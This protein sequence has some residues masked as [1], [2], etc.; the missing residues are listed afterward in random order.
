MYTK[1]VQLIN[2][3]P[4]EKLDIELPFDGETPKPVILVGENGSGKSILLSHLVDGLLKAKDTVYPQTP[5]IETGRVYKF[6]TNFYIKSGSQFSFG[7]VDFEEDF[8]VSE[9][10]TMRPKQEYSEVPSGMLGTAAEPIWRRMDPV[11]SDH[12]D[13]NLSI[14]YAAF[15][16]LK[17]I[18]ARNCVLYFPF[19]RFEEPAW[20]NHENLTAE[21]QYV[22]GKRLVDHTGRRAIALSPLH[23]NQ[24]WI[25][26][27]IYDRRVPETRT[28]R[29]SMPTPVGTNPWYLEAQQAEMRSH[30]E[31]VLSTA[32]QVV[33]N[34][35]RDY[36]NASFRIGRRRNRF[37]ALHGDNGT[38]VP[39]I[40]QLSSG[41][42]SLLN[43]FLSIL[44][45]YEWTD[46]QFSSATEIRGIVVVDEVDLHLHAIHQHE[47]LPK[48]IAM[49]PNV[50]FI[51]TTHSP[52]FVLG[53]QQTFGEDGFGIYR[54]SE[55]DRISAEEFS[56]FSE[57]YKTFSATRRFFN[58]LHIAIEEAQKPVLLTEG[59]TDEKYIRRASELLGR[60]EAL[61]GFEIRDGG[62]SG[63][64]ANVWKNYKYPMT[65]LVS[66]KVVLLFDCDKN[67][68][69]ENRENLF[70]RTIPFQPDN[71][72]ET[73]IENLFS[74]STLD[75]ATQYKAEFI[76]I[77]LEHKGTK[78]GVEI[79][80]LEK[81]TV[82][83]D[84]K[85]NLCNWIC[86]N[87]T[88]EDF[89]QFGVIFD[90]M[91]EVLGLNP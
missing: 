67:R 64:L 3:G 35:L 32:L 49:F 12:P 29:V 79:V 11:A 19:N 85:M 61:N 43:L 65:E 16:R 75:K 41:E 56:E 91:E 28:V 84:E 51:L 70:Q 50:Q 23:E 71:P 62:G 66:Q 26:D 25:F 88:A 63:N 87:G 6:R 24:N 69:S 90:L 72:V 37:V 46:S 33:Q 39:N 48:L 7:R 14:D 68:E 86:E 83:S 40:F 21:V 76:D 58:D 34:V 74:R 30:D 1:R 42:T 57:A 15:N 80:I 18:F 78:R 53:M 20:L 89:Q 52:L 81:C 27:V 22:G 2:Y 8:Y 47:V 10:T 59:D 9:L 4:I 60:E 45:D 77:E 44:R 5:E 55:G 31:G 36:P 82:N 54:L 38:I 13:S 17:G 73:G